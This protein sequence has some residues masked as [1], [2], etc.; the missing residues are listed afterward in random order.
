MKPFFLLAALYSVISMV[1]WMGKYTFTHYPSDLVVSPFQWHAHEL[2]YGFTLAV[3]AGFLL[4]ALP[5]WP[6]VSTVS[7]GKL[8]GLLQLWL[9]PRVL[10]LRGT[11]FLEI[12]ALFDLLFSFALIAAVAHPI[13]P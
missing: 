7:G 9:V 11:S 10:F 8:G 13:T 6:N 3:I 1:W 2:V 5:E 12:A 4:A